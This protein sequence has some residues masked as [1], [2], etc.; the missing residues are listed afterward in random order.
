MVNATD[1]GYLIKGHHS[2]TANFP[3]AT[4]MIFQQTAAPT[5]WTKDTTSVNERALRVV[6]GTASAGGSVGFTTAFSSSR[7]TS[8]ESSHTHG[9]GT[10]T[11]SSP[12]GTAS[13]AGGGGSAASSVHIHTITGSTAIGSSHSHTS[14]LAVLYLDVII[15][16][17]D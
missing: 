8:S 9:A 16:D 2:A 1:D 17:K 3:S 5:G 6:S 13:V 10:L 11:N 7:S 14:N 12:S 15:A 4:R